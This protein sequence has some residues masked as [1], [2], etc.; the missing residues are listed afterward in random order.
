MGTGPMKFFIIRGPHR[1]GVIFMDFR[2][3]RCLQM[4]LE[5]RL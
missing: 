1:K 3:V 5:I 2:V 4:G